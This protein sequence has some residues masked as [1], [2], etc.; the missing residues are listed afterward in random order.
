MFVNVGTKSSNW[1]KGVKYLMFSG[2]KVS[3]YTRQYQVGFLQEKVSIQ[4]KFGR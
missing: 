1:V 3:K 2:I 4:S